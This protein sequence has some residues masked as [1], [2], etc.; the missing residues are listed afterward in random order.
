M[1]D[2]WD[3][4]YLLDRSDRNDL[5]KADVKVAEALD[6][7]DRLSE[8]RFILYR[9]IDKAKR[10]LLPKIKGRV[11]ELS[12]KVLSERRG[13]DWYEMLS[14]YD[15]WERDVKI[16]VVNRALSKDGA[17]E[18][19]DFK[20]FVL[21]KGK[22]VYDVMERL[23]ER[24]IDKLLIIY[25][26]RKSWSAVECIEIAF[27]EAPAESVEVL[28]KAL[29]NSPPSVKVCVLCRNDI[30]PEYIM[31][32]IKALSKLTTQ[33]DVVV[34]LEFGLL[35]RLG[36][37]DRLLAIR[38]LFGM[39]GSTYRNWMWLKNS[40]YVESYRRQAFKEKYDRFVAEYV[41]PFV[42]NPTKDE[43]GELVFA[44]SIKKSEEVSEIL[45]RYDELILNRS[46]Q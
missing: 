17:I 21:E 8:V 32:G 26:R 11:N 42:T 12:R 36:P 37:R 1:K 6:S 24:I 45:N 43:F 25:K 29:S 7:M 19:G 35:H 15:W 22:D 16:E 5:A 31:V 18:V 9:Y 2:V 40:G 41:S 13:V 3:Y 23:H 14:Y 27:R 10:G 34:K 44:C 4:I 28:C 30:T 46:G 33:R 20:A 38:Q 39:L